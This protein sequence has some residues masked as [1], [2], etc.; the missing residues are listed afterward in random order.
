MFNHFAK[1]AIFA[2]GKASGGL[3]RIVESYDSNNIS[4][5]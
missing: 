1:Q 2:M 5:Q 4:S 3:V